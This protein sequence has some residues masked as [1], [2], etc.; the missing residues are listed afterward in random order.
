MKKLF[1]IIIAIVLISASYILLKNIK[2][3]SPKN[4]CSDIDPIIVT[5]QAQ[6]IED[7]KSNYSTTSRRILGRSTEGGT[8]LNYID[9]NKIVLIEQVF[10]GETGKAYSSYYLVNNQVYYFHR[11]LHTYNLPIYDSKFDQSKDVIEIQDYYL[12]NKQMLCSWYSNQNK[13]SISDAVKE[14]VSQ[15]IKGLWE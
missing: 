11:E 7:Q 9:G 14:F 5:K 4:S 8:Q 13:Q 3:E 6:I 15:S 1:I 2:T 10:Y 12:D